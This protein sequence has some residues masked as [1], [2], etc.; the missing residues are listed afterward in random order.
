MYSIFTMNDS[1]LYPFRFLCFCLCLTLGLFIN[2][3]QEKRSLPSP[4]ESHPVEV[5]SH[6]TARN[7]PQGLHPTFDFFSP[8]MSLLNLT[9]TT[10]DEY[11]NQVPILL[12][13]L[14]EISEDGTRCT[15][16]LREDARWP[17]GKP[18]TRE[19]VH[20][21]LKVL[22][23]PSLSHPAIP[24][25][26]ETLLQYEANAQNPNTFTLITSP[27]QLNPYLSN[28][29]VAMP[30][31]I[32]DPDGSWD[33]I[34]IEEA[35][36]PQLTQAYPALFPWV[37][38]F[39]GV[40]DYTEIKEG[41][42]EFPMGIGPYQVAEWVENEY[43]RLEARANYWGRGSAPQ[44]FLDAGVKHITYTLTDAVQAISTQQVDVVTDL[45]PAAIGTFDEEVRAQ[46]QFEMV[47]GDRYACIMLNT[48][49]DPVNGASFL[50]EKIN[51]QALRYLMPID[52]MVARRYGSP[53]VAEAIVSPVPQ[54]LQEY[55]SQLS[56]QRYQPTKA[57]QLLEQAGWEDHNGDG[58]L[59]RIMGGKRMSFE[60]SLMYKG[61]N[62][63]YEVIAQQVRSALKKAG[64]VC[65]L[66]PIDEK[67][68][69]EHAMAGEF[70]AVI[71]VFSY[72]RPIS[73]FKQLWH[74]SARKGQGYN[75]S[76]FG[77]AQTDALI[78]RIRATTDP[79]LYT[80]LAQEFQAILY[81][82]QP[83]LFLFA[84]K[85]GIGIRKVYS[86]DNIQVR[87]PFV[88]INNLKLAEEQEVVSYRER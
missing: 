55:N 27:N 16:T 44:E 63:T 23:S 35:K 39:L 17:D 3:C 38:S 72:Q 36:N 22:C 56:P 24:G 70:D 75:F 30:K 31:H 68:L 33:T 88:R 11:G 10:L 82:E 40:G 79:S 76:N 34:S 28:Y 19:D 12:S 80:Q 71:R 18:L 83:V 6:I 73:D 66:V 7:F 69:M 78:D 67:K 4:L 53:E 62:T 58:I 85:R 45:S 43:I 42:Q 9:L 46:Y 14:P 21:S 65:H 8:V 37:Q 26:F 64:I 41:N 50:Q 61:Q 59:D 47:E 1:S 57:R 29:M 15:Y 60:F 32:H 49:P 13:Q 87:P 54:N 81:E 74:T 5:S 48:K 84:P 86:R 52:S 2:S 77:N 51:R 20:F 25:Y